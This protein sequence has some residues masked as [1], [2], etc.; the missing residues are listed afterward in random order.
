MKKRVTSILLSICLVAGM[1]FGLPGV[2]AS[3]K[4]DKLI[5]ITFDDGPGPYTAGLLDG[6]KERGAKATFFM[7]G[8]NAAVYPDLVK[9]A[10]DEGHEIANHSWSHI[11]F[12]SSE[13]TAADIEKQ[14]M[15]TN[16]ELEKADGK[17]YHLVRCPYGESND[18]VVSVANSPIIYWTI[19]TNDWKNTDNPSATRDAIVSGAYDGAISLEHDIHENSVVGTLQAIDILKEDGYT[20]VTVSELIQR[21][22]IDTSETVYDGKNTGVDLPAAT[23]EPPE[24]PI[25][26]AYVKKSATLKSSTDNDASVKGVIS[27]DSLVG[28]LNKDDKKKY[29]V[30]DAWGNKGFVD[31]SNLVI[32]EGSDLPEAEQPK[33]TEA[34]SP[35]AEP[36]NRTSRTT[37]SLDVRSAVKGGT[38]LARIPS[39]VL[40][41]VLEK[42]DDDNVMV[43]TDGGVIGYVGAKHLKNAR[44]G[45]KRPANRHPEDKS[46]EYKPKETGVATNDLNLRGNSSTQSEIITVV[47]AGTALTVLETP[48]GN[49]CR[50]KT[51]GGQEGYVRTYCVGKGPLKTA[52]ATDDVNF[53]PKASTDSD[54]IALLNAGTQVQILDS[55]T[56]GWYLV[57]TSDAQVGYVSADFVKV[58]KAENKDT[59]KDA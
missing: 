47:K 57:L 16:A 59:K 48:G 55:S 25:G 14:I 1:V 56:K 38:T 23:P 46:V 31:A 2:M 12:N 20:F 19:D 35:P 10:A 33:E 18:T 15:D 54:P 13:T 44:V 37:K 41:T 49:W 28:L 24:E 58:E 3:A 29:K 40:V 32:M 30:Q 8:Q 5:A 50:V 27:A 11:N 34:V 42:T 53:R 51:E 39:G 4:G 36:L 6:L 52:K 9:R 22:G 7:L 43:K 17:K 45:G 26:T 21:R